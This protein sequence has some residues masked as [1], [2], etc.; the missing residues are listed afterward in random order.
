MHFSRTF[1]FALI[2]FILSFIFISCNNS[3]STTADI[4]LL[5]GN[6]TTIND[7]MPHAEA[8]AIK[9]DTIQSIGNN[10]EIKKLVGEDTEVIDLNGKFNQVMNISWSLQI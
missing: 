1:N 8:I 9:S 2:I 10:S 3:K 6:I 7:A 4:V 5:N